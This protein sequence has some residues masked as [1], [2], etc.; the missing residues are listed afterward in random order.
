[1][2]RVETG[3]SEANRIFN[4]L[5]EQACKHAEPGVLFTNKLRNYNLME[6]VDSYQIETTN[7]CGS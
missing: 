4:I 1:M 3:D 7:P 2:Q 5:C 6:Y